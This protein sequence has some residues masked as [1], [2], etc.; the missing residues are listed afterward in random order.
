M[1]SIKNHQSSTYCLSRIFVVEIISINNKILNATLQNMYLYSTWRKNLWNHVMFKFEIL[2][3][4]TRFLN[5][6]ITSV[7][8]YKQMLVVNE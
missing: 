2:L 8:F 4:I 5:I 3:I 1:T 7:Y 6:E